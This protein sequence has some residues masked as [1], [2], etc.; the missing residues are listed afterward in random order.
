M[1]ATRKAILQTSD[2]AQLIDAVNQVYCPHELKIRGNYSDVT[3]TLQVIRAG[4][5]PI[6]GLKYST[7]VSIDPG[8]FP[9]LC[10][11]QTCIDG[12]ATVVQAGVSTEQCRGQTVPL[13]PGLSTQLE[14]GKRFAE[15]SLRVS[16]ERLEALCSRWLN[17]PL[18]RPV[19]FELRAFAPELERAWGEA[20]A[21]L[22][23]YDRMNILLP[24]AAALSL[25]EF[26]LSL[27]LAQHEHNYSEELRKRDRTAAP[28]IVR[29]AEHWMRT[30]SADTTVSRIAARVGVSLRSLQAGFQHYRQ[31]TPSQVLRQIRLEAVRAELLAPSE[32][33][34]VTAAALGNGFF[35]LS[36]FSAYYRD[37]YQEKPLQ[38]LRR[39]QLRRGIRLVR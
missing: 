34:T 16:L 32:S 2:L 15:T 23:S 7:A 10:L 12:S 9:H 13:S 11:M 3:G 20:V 19:R 24:E 5:Q 36:R 35:H 38:T 4:A 39:G 17:Y 25:D 30:A 33:T 29:E 37:V 27:P 1:D 18:E 31:A 14:F 8:D 6:I 26:L 28:R 21:L 22:L